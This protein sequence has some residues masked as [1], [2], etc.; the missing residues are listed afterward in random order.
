MHSESV[1]PA[2]I[3]LFEVRDDAP[4]LQKKDAGIYYHT[5]MQLLYLANSACTDILP[6]LL[7]LTTIL[8]EPNI[9]DWKNLPHACK[10]LEATKYPT[11]TLDTDDLHV[12]NWYY[13]VDFEVHNGICIR[14][15]IVK[16]LGKVFVNGL[17]GK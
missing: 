17:S 11:L 16:T 14:N 13:V 3:H 2:Y 12:I 5:T 15:R 6:T 7:H 10:Y 4:N 8:R 9:N 1:T